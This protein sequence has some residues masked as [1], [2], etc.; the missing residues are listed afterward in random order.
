[1]DKTET[2]NYV[3]YTV[4]RPN[5]APGMA[6]QLNTSEHDV[7][8]CI[9]YAAPISGISLDEKSNDLIVSM[10]GSHGY[11]LPSLAHDLVDMLHSSP[12]RVLIVAVDT[13]QRIRFSAS[14]GRLITEQPT[15]VH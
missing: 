1:M 15:S 4:L 9:P 2:P 12:D 6:S 13:L 7:C 14:A 10:E 5:Y 8:V 11:K 3:G